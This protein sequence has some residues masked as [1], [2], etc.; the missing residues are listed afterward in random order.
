VRTLVL[1][2]ATATGKSA[3]AARVAQQA[4]FEVVSMDSMQIYRGIPIVSAQPEP[5]L[6]ALAPHHLLEIADPAEHF[7]T[8]MYL[9]RVRQALDAIHARGRGALLVG[10]TAL[11]YRSLTRGLS[12]LPSAD[13]ALRAELIEAERADPGVLH[14]RLAEADPVSAA[15]LH[16]NDTRRLVRALEVLH[17]SGVPLSELVARPKHPVLTDFVAVGIAAPRDRLYA[18]IDMRVVRMWSAGLVEEIRALRDRLPAGRHTIQQAI[19]YPQIVGYLD[20]QYDEAEAKRL[21]MRDSRR[22]ARRQLSQF[23]GEPAV[24]WTD[25]ALFPDVDAL[26][27]AALDPA[28]C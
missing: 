18:R 12:D 2:G 3:V 10:G 8:A 17:V 22:F 6:L 15:R 19:G 7:D 14:R 24:R 11:Y 9:S 4:N 16:A 28:G 25:E 23:T 5:E 27:R 21:V 1:V 13:E 26:V 20:G